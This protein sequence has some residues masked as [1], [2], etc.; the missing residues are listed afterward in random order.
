MGPTTMPR[1]YPGSQLSLLQDIRKK[2]SL[3]Q[4]LQKKG[5]IEGLSLLLQIK[6]QAEARQA[7]CGSP[8]G[9]GSADKVMHPPARSKVLRAQELGD[10]ELAKKLSS[11]VNGLRAR[12]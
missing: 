12:P 4:K 3:L 8:N 9:H 7:G 10:E 6:R 11:E 5:V 1:E 2:P